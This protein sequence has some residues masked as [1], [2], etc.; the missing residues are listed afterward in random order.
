MRKPL[1]IALAAS[2]CLSFVD[3][4]LDDKGVSA[5]ASSTTFTLNVPQ[6]GFVDVTFNNVNRAPSVC[7]NGAGVVIPCPEPPTCWYYVWDPSTGESGTRPITCVYGVTAGDTVTLCGSGIMGALPCATPGWCDWYFDF[8]SSPLCPANS[9]S[10]ILNLSGSF[11]LSEYV[12]N[13]G[14]DPSTRYCR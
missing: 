8:W 11:T 9:A 3:S 14:Y 5:A 1:V 13:Y 6:N 7:Y 10:C 4:S 2:F 12:H